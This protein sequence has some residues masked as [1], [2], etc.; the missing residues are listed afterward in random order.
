M[1]STF[2]VTETAACFAIIGLEIAAIVVGTCA[3]S[4]C[5]GF[6]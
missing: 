6:S 2:K 1:N 3:A 4:V 5:S